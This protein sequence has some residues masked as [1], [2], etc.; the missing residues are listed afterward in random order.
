MFYLYS[1]DRCVIWIPAR[2]D[3]ITQMGKCDRRHTTL[4]CLNPVKSSCTVTRK[5]TNSGIFPH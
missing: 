1:A 3:F 2:P 4:K 5:A